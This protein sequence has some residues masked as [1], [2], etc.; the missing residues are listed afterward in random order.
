MGLG[1][2]IIKYIVKLLNG[3]IKVKSEFGIGSEFIVIIL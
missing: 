1:L 2:V 3:C